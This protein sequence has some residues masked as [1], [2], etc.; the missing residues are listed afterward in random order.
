MSR[1][2]FNDF[3]KGLTACVLMFSLFYGFVCLLSYW[4]GEDRKEEYCG[5]LYEGRH[6]YARVTKEVF[7]EHTVEDGDSL[8]EKAAIKGWNSKTC[9]QYNSARKNLSVKLRD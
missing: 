9:E 5:E 7:L 2:D 8:G 4:K 1:Q 6:I 3:L